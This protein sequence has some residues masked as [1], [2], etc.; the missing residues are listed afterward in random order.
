[1]EI[2]ASRRL[3]AFGG[4][5]FDEI[6]RAVQALADQGVAV[7]DFG[8]G[9]PRDPTPALVRRAGQ[10]AIDRHA[11]SGYPSYVGSAAYRQAVA[12]WTARRFGVTLDPATEVCSTIGSKEAVFHF[13]EALLDPGDVVL[14]PSPGYPPY[15]RGTLFAEGRVWTCPLDAE[16]GFLPDLAAIPRDIA[17]AARL[18]WFCNP[19]APTGRV[20]DRAY[21]EG[22]VRFCAEHEI[23]LAADEAYS[24]IWFESGPPPSALEVARDGVVVFHSLSKRSAMTGWRVGWM[25]GDERLVTLFRKVKTNIDS[26]TPDF[27]QEAAV[28][29]L[30]DEAHVAG[31]RTAY[32]EKRDV[33]LAAFA[34]AGLAVRAPEAT[35]YVWQRAP[36]GMDGLAFA[37]RLLAP[38][39]AV[40]TIPGAALAEPTADGRNPGAPYVRLALCP[41]LEETR[42][43]AERIAALRF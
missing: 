31:M 19:N 28:A 3:R 5:A 17:R 9:D 41:S 42:A 18:L 2:R 22:L 40:A 38:D 12:A 8:V 24:E 16:N 30:S 35:L 21:L 32:R 27:V 4:Y 7:T 36:E 34:A 25:A 26:G 43:A 39:V 1:M 6:D 10:A 37:K 14:V 23:I 13:P 11:T 33:L 20:A 15:T 29:A